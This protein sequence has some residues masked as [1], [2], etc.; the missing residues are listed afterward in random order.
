MLA[1]FS[2][3]MRRWRNNVFY[4]FLQKIPFFWWVCVAFSLIILCVKGLRPAFNGNNSS[5]RPCLQFCLKVKV[6]GIT[7][8]VKD[9]LLGLGMDNKISLIIMMTF[10]ELYFGFLCK[11]ELLIRIINAFRIV[12]FQEGQYSRIFRIEVTLVFLE[13]NWGL[14]YFRKLF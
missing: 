14:I 9:G 8:I 6:L 2:I 4:F 10:L 7:S 13:K 11:S 1:F 3:Y 5:L 12:I